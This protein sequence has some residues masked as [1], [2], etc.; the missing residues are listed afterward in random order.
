M[1]EKIYKT[2]A[3][4]ATLEQYDF[5]GEVVFNGIS[6]TPLTNIKGA[7][8]RVPNS[9]ILV[10]KTTEKIIDGHNGIFKQGFRDFLSSYIAF[11]EGKRLLLKYDGFL[12]RKTTDRVC[13]AD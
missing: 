4:H 3:G 2:A 6:L 10:V 11:V 13:T 9:P 8:G 5:T 12:Q 1:D 7:P